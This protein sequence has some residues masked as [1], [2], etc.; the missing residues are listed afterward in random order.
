MH[1]ENTVL[2]LFLQDKWPSKVFW[3]CEVLIK[4]DSWHCGEADSVTLLSTKW[5]G[6]LL[7]WGRPNATAWQYPQTDTKLPPA[8]HFA[9]R[10]SSA[11]V[12]FCGPPAA[13][14]F[15]GFLLSECWEQHPVTPLSIMA[16]VQVVWQPSSWNSLEVAIDATGLDCAAWIRAG[17]AWLQ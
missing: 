12:L 8:D 17:W 15:E 7:K 2:L 9:P 3:R 4:G 10:W 1:A 11:I 14:G 13:G 16:A 5:T 6:F